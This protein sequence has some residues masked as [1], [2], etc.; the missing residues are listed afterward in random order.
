MAESGTVRSYKSWWRGWCAVLLLL[1]LQAGT[2]VHAQKG[3]VA[4]DVLDQGSRLLENGHKRAFSGICSYGSRVLAVG[5]RGLILRSEDSGTSWSQV[6]SPVSSDLVSVRFSNS[7]TA[8]VVGHD[9]VILRS[10]DGGKNWERVLDGR[11]ILR[12]LRESGENIQKEVA[13]TMAQSASKDVW[14]AALFDIWF[15]ADGEKG[16]AVGA[17]GL[18]LRTSDGGKHWQSW[19]ARTDNDRRNHLYAVNGKSDNLYIAGEQGVLLRL[20]DGAQQFRRIETPYSGSYFGIDVR[21]SRLVVYGL[22]GTV[23]FSPDKGKTWK[24]I[25]T[26]VDANLVSAIADG[27]ELLLV[28]QSGDILRTRLESGQSLRAASHPGAEIYGAALS[29]R[30]SMVLARLNGVT[31]VGLPGGEK[32]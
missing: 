14:P 25:D 19:I 7:E 4:V 31:T 28:S 27:D 5:P 18:I 26:G 16:F 24:K 17:F 6:S 20:D 8:W 29:G 15:S 9:A 10:T 30:A 12:I 11:A 3:K 32:K 23:Y 22:R 13:R 21:D 2:W 1:S